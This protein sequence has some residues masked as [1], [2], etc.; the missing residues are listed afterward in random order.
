MSTIVGVFAHPDDEAFG[1]GGT[2]AKMARDNDVYII[3]CTDGNHQEKGLKNVRDKEL[4]ASA[5]VLDVKKVIFLN[6]EDGELCNAN[7]HKLAENLRRELDKLKPETII[8]FHPNGVSGHI[9]HIVV[10][11]VVNFLFHKLKYL[12]KIMYFC[13]RDLER[14]MIPNYFVHMPEGIARQNTDQIIDVSA[15]WNIKNAA[16]R[17]HKSQIKDLIMVT[18]MQALLPKEEYFVVKIK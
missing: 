12:K 6:F 18:A 9:D 16:M 8:T 3:C 10:T 4:L 2:L 7:Y 1:P 15:V 14:Q 5:K 13:L 11:S 17:K